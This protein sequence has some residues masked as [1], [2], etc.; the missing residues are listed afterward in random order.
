MCGYLLYLSSQTIKM[1]IIITHSEYI[2]PLI[3][4]AQTCS[5]VTVRTPTRP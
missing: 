5:T 3:E 4:H 2:D 1:I